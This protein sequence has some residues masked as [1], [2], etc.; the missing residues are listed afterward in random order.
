MAINTVHATLSREFLSSCSSSVLVLSWRDEYVD[1]MNQKISTIHK[2]AIYGAK[3]DW[4]YL[5]W[6]LPNLL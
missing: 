4:Y 5:N 1:D 6:G 2:R 3:K